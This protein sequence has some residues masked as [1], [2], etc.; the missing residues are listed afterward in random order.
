M[1]CQRQSLDSVSAIGLVFLAICRSATAQ[2]EPD[3]LRVD[4]DAGSLPPPA[5]IAD[6]SAWTQNLPFRLL[7]D[8]I[9]DCMTCCGSD[10][11]VIYE[12]ICKVEPCTA[13]CPPENCE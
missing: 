11:L 5:G 7:Q 9:Q 10:S 13:G 8:A 12:C 1:S 6:G 3:K 4:G 2:P